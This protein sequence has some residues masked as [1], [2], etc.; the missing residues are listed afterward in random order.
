M[1]YFSKIGYPC[2]PFTNPSDFFMKIMNPQ[3]LLIEHMEKGEVLSSDKNLKLIQEFNH[4]LLFFVD[5]YRNTEFFKNFEPQT[6][7]PVKIEK[8]VNSVPW[9]SQFG[10]IM[11]RETTTIWRNPFDLRV[12]VMQ[13]V[14]F[15]LICAAVYQDVSF[16]KIF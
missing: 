2:P 14:V 6:L 9:I 11:K 5:S 12:K 7:P 10:L 1:D 4:R 13:F 3:G 15:A 8:E 16:M